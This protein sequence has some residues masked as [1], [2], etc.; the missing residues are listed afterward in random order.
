[1]INTAADGE[2]AEGKGSLSVVGTGIQALS[3]LTTQARANIIHAD[4][5][6]YLVT[7]SVTE[8]YLQDLNS[9]AESLH[10][11][12]ASGKERMASYEEM[13]ERILDPVREGRNVCAA[14]Y[15]HPGVFVFPSHEAIR[16]ARSEGYFAEMVPAI[17][18]EDCLF[19][20]LGVEPAIPGCQSFEATDFLICARKFDPTSSL[21]LWQ[22]GVIGHLTFEGEGYEYQPGLE[23]LTEYLLQTYPPEHVV[24]VYEAAHLPTD[25]PRRDPV[26]LADLASTPVTPVSTLY[27][28]PREQAR[29]DEDMLARLGI[30]KESLPR[31]ERTVILSRSPTGVS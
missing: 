31:V 21:V 22:I 3:H 30:S 19:A 23:I 4:R 5:V 16:R 13:V 12:Y 25:E 9:R 14:F 20:D 2:A 10:P 29:L 8:R 26:V 1:M 27:V 6:L 15:G 28:P 11:L 18:A 7:D 17:S 24:V